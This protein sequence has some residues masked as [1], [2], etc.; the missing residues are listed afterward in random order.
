MGGSR[1]SGNDSAKAIEG[2][3][4]DSMAVSEEEDSKSKSTTQQDEEC[5]SPDVPTKMSMEDRKAKFSEL[6]KKMVH[7][8]N[9]PLSQSA[10]LSSLAKG[11]IIESKPCIPS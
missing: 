7:A 1:S 5:Q 6:R 4:E 11:R 2:F 8:F 9:L 10:H 3:V